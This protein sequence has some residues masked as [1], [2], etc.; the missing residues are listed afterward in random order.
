M[1]KSAGV[2]V[3]FARFIVQRISEGC[4]V[5]SRIGRDGALHAEFKNDW[6]EGV[7]ESNN[8]TVKISERLEPS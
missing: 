6:Q 1:A 4:L 3:L 2:K 7:T 5:Y 8:R